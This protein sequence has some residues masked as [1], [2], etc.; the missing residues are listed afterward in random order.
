MPRLSPRNGKV[1]RLYAKWLDLRQ[2]RRRNT[3][4]NGEDDIFDALLEQDAKEKFRTEERSR[5]SADSRASYRKGAASAIFS[6][7]LDL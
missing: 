2:Q 3:A 1:G 7:D 6:E 5:Y 4:L